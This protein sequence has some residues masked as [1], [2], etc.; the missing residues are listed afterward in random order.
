MGFKVKIDGDIRQAMAA[1]A[2][3][4]HR[5]AERAVGDEVKA[6]AKDIRRRAPVGDSSRGRRGKPPLAESVE[7][8]SNGLD[9]AA[10]VK[11]R[12]V[13][14]IEHGTKNR[15]ARPIVR[16]AAETARR[17]FPGR[18]ADEIREAIE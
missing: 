3:A 1:K 12:H 10:R 7:A 9:G 13:N 18:V 11:A 2:A 14:I 6:V 5:G 16:P 17:R 8:T 4:I 15:P